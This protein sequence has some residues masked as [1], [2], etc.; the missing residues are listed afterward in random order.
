MT[1][2]KYNLLMLE[3]DECVDA[4]Y[5]NTCKKHI[6]TNCLEAHLNSSKHRWNTQ[7]RLRN[8]AIEEHLLFLLGEGRLCDYLPGHHQPTFENVAHVSFRLLSGEIFAQLDVSMTWTGL[9]YC[10]RNLAMMMEVHPALIRIEYTGA[11]PFWIGPD[12]YIGRTGFSERI[13]DHCSLCFLQHSPM[14]ECLFCGAYVCAV[15]FKCPNW[16]EER[17]RCWGCMVQ[18]T[19]LTPMEKARKLIV[20]VCSMAQEPS[21]SQRL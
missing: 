12:A 10:Q 21:G 15:C 4:G 6:R 5:C 9:L 1:L 13:I 17:C 18:S 2:C 14:A 19:E 3:R 8:S 20:G 11:Q 16:A 7:Y